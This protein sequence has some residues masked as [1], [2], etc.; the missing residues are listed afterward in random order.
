MGLG[1]VSLSLRK[2]P[3]GHLVAGKYRLVEH[4]GGGGMGEV[5]RAEH[6]FAGRM[7]AIKLLR[8]DLA[9]SEDLARRLFFEAQA[10]NKIRHPNIVDVIDAGVA[11][12]GPYIVMEYLH[13]TSLAVAIEKEGH[14]DAASAVAIAVPVLN[15]LEAAHV[16]G[17]VHRDLKPGNVFLAAGK[18]GP[19]VKVL[20][21]G[22]AKMLGEGAGPMNAVETQA[23]TVFGTPRYMSP[24]QAQAKPLDARSDLYSLGVI[25]YHMLAGRPPFT[26][27]DAIIVMARHIKS[28]PKPFSDVC[29]DAHIPTEVEKVVF[30]TMAKDPANRPANADEM[31]Q[32]IVAAFEHSRAS[33]SGVRSAAVRSGSVRPPPMGTSMAPG[34]PAQPEAADSLEVRSVSP[35]KQLPKSF[36]A[37]AAAVGVIAVVVVAALAI[38]VL[39][40]PVRQPIVVTAAPPATTTQVTPTATDTATKPLATTSTDVPTLD[41]SALPTAKGPA[42][43][44]TGH[45]PP[46]TAAP[47]ASSAADRYGRLE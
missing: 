15:A 12:E 6:A 14:L 22:I 18:S 34:A 5:F 13:G 47:G 40:E 20:D 46:G 4:L 39:R 45:K 9:A 30:R 29:P 38:R 37:L 25:L 42:T 41:V 43:I 7:V 23:G 31:A 44:H 2:L 28:Q 16:E 8:P 3:P 26:D 27:D 36:V 10:V 19:I 33:A 21:F 24:E 32:E 1:S 11:D 17:I 35:A